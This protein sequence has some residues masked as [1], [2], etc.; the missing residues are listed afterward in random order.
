MIEVFIVIAIYSAIV[1]FVDKPLVKKI[2]NSET[3][4]EAV[5]NRKRLIR[6]RWIVTTV[7]F[8]VYIGGS[9]CIRFA[10]DDNW[11][12]NPENWKGIIM[13]IIFCT[14]ELSKKKDHSP[15]CKISTLTIDSI[16]NSNQ[17]F[18]LFLRGFSSDDYSAIADLKAKKNSKDFSE[19]R[20]VKQLSK[21][22]PVYA[23]GMTKEV[24]CP[25]GAERIYLSDSTWKEDVRRLMI[26]AKRIVI[27]VN[28]KPN[29][30]WEIEQ[31]REMLEKTLFVVSDVQKYQ[32]VVN[33]N[34]IKD[35]PLV[36]EK[37]YLTFRNGS[38][39][40]N[41]FNSKQYSE[42]AK[43]AIKSDEDD[44]H[45]LHFMPLWAS[46]LLFIFFLFVFYIMIFNDKLSWIP[47]VV[48]WVCFIL[49]M[50]F[51][52]SKKSLK[53]Y[54]NKLNLSLAMIVFSILFL[55]AHVITPMNID[56]E[57]ILDPFPTSFFYG[58]LFFCVSSAINVILYLIALVKRSIH[59]VNALLPIG[60]AE[61]VYSIQLLPFH[62]YD[63][64]LL[65]QPVFAILASGILIRRRYNQSIVPRHAEKNM[66]KIVTSLLVVIS[67]FVML[68]AIPVI[69]GKKLYA[70][71]GK[72]LLGINEFRSAHFTTFDDYVDIANDYADHEDEYDY[73]H[74]YNDYFICNPDLA[75]KYYLMAYEQG[76]ISFQKY[77]YYYLA[78]YYLQKGN[79][80][81]AIKWYE[82]FLSEIDDYSLLEKQEIAKKELERLSPH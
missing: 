80:E 29:C 9:V 40:V 70:H 5:I 10:I 37:S 17:D 57:N 39:N 65:L 44:T 13:A 38:W 41:K 23:V 72:Y 77:A 21:Y 34:V 8:V 6:V 15:F 1:A 71:P 24:E 75:V 7:F 49:Y 36:T 60:F 56:D 32:A 20:I 54:N 67:V 79:K 64:S 2:K 35:I 4:Q 45:K 33:A 26:K 55:I 16:C 42:V 63:P 22:M 62:F 30:V 31:S 27:E 69:E 12:V 28:D 14:I 43:A 3:A 48:L 51:V 53:K 25:H 82:I 18:V 81:D 46:I 76:E 66:G 61:L 11:I 19:Y 50:V 59:A 52:A 47:I 58:S 74:E 68:I 78:D 73:G